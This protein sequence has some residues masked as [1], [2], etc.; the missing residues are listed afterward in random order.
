VSVKNRFYRI[1]FEG[2]I[3]WAQA[4]GPE[5]DE[6]YPSD[7]QLRLLSGDPLAGGEP[8]NHLV[9]RASVEVLVPCTPTKIIGVARN[10]AAHAAERERAV[11]LEPLI[12]LKPL[13]TLTPTE[14]RFP[15][16]RSNTAAPNGPP[17]PS[18][19][20]RSVSASTKRM[21]SELSPIGNA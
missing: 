4:A 14:T 12:F 1:E 8:N 20:L 2:A 16:S 3:H 7:N 13:T 15:E 21:R 6:P 18:R 9:D 19:M 11:P 10:F 17:V 5:T